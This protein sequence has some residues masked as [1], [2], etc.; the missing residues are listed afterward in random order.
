MIRTVDDAWILM[1]PN[2]FRVV[3]TNRSREHWPNCHF[4]PRTLAKPP[5]CF[6][7]SRSI[8]PANSGEPFVVYFN[9]VIYNLHVCVRVCVCM[10]VLV[11][12]SLCVCVR[13]NV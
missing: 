3:V 4:V 1:F 6:A 13:V 5:M 12:T 2:P 9:H 7:C 10:F 8:R 11:C